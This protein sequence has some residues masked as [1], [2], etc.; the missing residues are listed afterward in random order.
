[1]QH[2]QRIDC[3]ASAAVPRGLTAAL[4]LARFRLTVQVVDRGA[5]RTASIPLTRNYP[6]FPDGITG[7][8]L[9]QRIGEI[10]GS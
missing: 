10:A 8:D 4:Y 7:R 5:G 2:N 1:M 3:L 6:D 9:V